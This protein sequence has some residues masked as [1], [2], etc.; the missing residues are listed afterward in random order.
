MKAFSAQLHQRIRRSPNVESFRFIAD[1][2]FDFLPGQFCQVIFDTSNPNNKEANKYLSFS[3]SPTKNYFEVT[4]KLSTSIFSNRLRSLKKGDKV[5]FKAP[6]GNCVFKDSFKKVGFLIGGI[7]I[8]PV[9]SILEYIVDKDINT[10]ALLLYS[11]STEE[12]I[13]F[14]QELDTWQSRNRR[15]RVIFTVTS[16]Q[17]QDERCERGYIDKELLHK[18]TDDVKE[19]IFYIFGPPKMVDAMKNICL[20]SECVAE[21]IKIENFVGY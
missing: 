15:I 7:G 17:P 11:N 19:R 20:E 1:Q 5:S 3:S 4:K 2:S 21:N 13:A 8:T 14:K 6:F 9:I 16:C 18:K 10:D 12:D